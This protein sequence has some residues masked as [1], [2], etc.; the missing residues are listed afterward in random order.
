ML[1]RSASSRT[2]SRPKAV[3]ITTAGFS[4]IAGSCLIRRVAVSP[5]TPGILQSMKTTS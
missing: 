2:S 1:S 4:W 5:S 3:T